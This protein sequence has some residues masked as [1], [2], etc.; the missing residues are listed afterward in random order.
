MALKTALWGEPIEPLIPRP[1]THELHLRHH[2]T[3]SDR[4]LLDQLLEANR[5]RFGHGWVGLLGTCAKQWLS[6]SSSLRSSKTMHIP[7]SVLDLLEP[8]RREIAPD[9][10]RHDLFVAIIFQVSSASSAPSLSDPA[11]PMLTY[12]SA[13]HHQCFPG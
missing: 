10:T 8:W 1:S 7:G 4:Q 12:F 13:G 11:Y 9:A 5:A 3:V 6:R 2:P